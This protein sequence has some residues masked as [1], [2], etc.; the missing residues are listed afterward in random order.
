MRKPAVFL[1]RDGTI[2]EEVGYLNHIDRFR[3]FPFAGAAIGRLNEAGLAVIVVTNQSGV[4]RGYFPESLVQRVN[5]RMRLELNAAGARLDGIYYCP[6]GSSDGCECRK[7]KT[8]MLEQAAREHKID[9]PRSFVVGDRYAD[10]DLAFRAGCKAIFVQTG[11][12]LGEV[13]WHGKEWPQQPDA[14]VENLQAATEWILAR[15]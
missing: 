1:D 9:L 6:H 13:K 2:V 5:E 12:G 3:M 15:T 10:M 7:P 11:Y 8:G 14:I 4:A